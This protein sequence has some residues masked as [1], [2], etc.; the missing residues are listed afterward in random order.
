MTTVLPPTYYFTNIDFN[1]T[2]YNPSSSYITT[3]QARNTFLQKKVPDYATA[4]ET[5]LA[6]IL[7]DSIQPYGVTS[8]LNIGNLATTT[9][10]QIGSSNTTGNIGMGNSL[11]TGNLN[12]GN[13]A[14]LGTIYFNMN[15][16]FYFPIGLS[17]TFANMPNSITQIGY[18]PYTTNTKIS[19]AA[20]T[21]IGAYS[22]YSPTTLLSAIGNYLF[23]M[24][25]MFSVTGTI[26]S[27]TI[28][29]IVIGYTFGSSATASANTVT[30]LYT[31]TIANFNFANASNKEIP[32]SVS[33]PISETTTTNYLAGYV[34]FSVSGAIIGGGTVQSSITSMSITRIG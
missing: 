16:N 1:N 18:S 17:Y 5:F 10:F 29:T 8:N 25:G 7:T 22:L 24:V 6:G 27:G 33:Y 32:F 26:T 20:V 2:Y 19:S 3:T 14:G 13:S 9:G 4:Q 31:N 11:T 34:T 28:G 15:T 23:T 21:A 30:S 12:F